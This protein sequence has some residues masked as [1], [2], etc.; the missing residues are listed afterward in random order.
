MKAGEAVKEN[1]VKVVQCKAYS[2]NSASSVGMEL[3]IDGVNQTE[4][5]PDVTHTHGA[6]NGMVKTF[7]FRFTTDRS[8][9]G[10]MVTCRLLWDGTYSG[11]KK[12]DYL[13]ITCE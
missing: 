8:Q 1:T 11:L 12:E 10:K 2:A 7:V 13:N 6:H 9:N 3:L 4:F 5:E